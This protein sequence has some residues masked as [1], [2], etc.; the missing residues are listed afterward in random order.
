MSKSATTTATKTETV[1][2][3]TSTPGNP[4]KPSTS[5]IA[6]PRIFLWGAPGAGKTR[7]SLSL[8]RAAYISLERG[9]QYY[10]EEFDF[11][12]MEP[13][14]FAE[15]VQAVTWLATHQHNYQTIVIDPVTIA[16]EMCQDD[17]LQA[18]KAARG[19]NA[20]IS[21][22]DWKTIKPR[23]NTL[24]KLLTTIDM[25]VVVIARATKN[26]VSGEAGSEMFA[27][28]K[29]DPETFQAE[30]N[31]AYI[32]DTELQLQADH[33]G[34]KCRYMA[35]TR[36]DRTGK[37][38]SGKWEFTGEAVRSYFGLIVDTLGSPI[39]DNAVCDSCSGDIEPYND[40]LPVE[41]AKASR[42]HF[43]GQALCTKCRAA[44][45]LVN[46]EVGQP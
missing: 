14:T 35:T 20:E 18:K 22:G 17:F 9:A 39:I 26:Y 32:F 8:G 27:I 19:P 4:F 3:S 31:T 13:Q 6:R 2:A 45:R 33:R 43:N 24:M 7:C 12:L 38:P 11:D 41:V 37:F 36:K 16:W 28:D 34:G 46:S 10:A 23:Y 5:V 42:E 25:N 40:M 15:I 30:K 1:P 44:A 29:N 21:G